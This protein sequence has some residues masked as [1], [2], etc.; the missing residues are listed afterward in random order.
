MA[1]SFIQ[2]F[3]LRLDPNSILNTA[4]FPWI[5]EDALTFAF[6]RGF[7][8]KKIPRYRV[9][10]LIKNPAFIKK[11]TEDYNDQDF[12]SFINEYQE[13]IHQIESELKSEKGLIDKY[14]LDCLEKIDST[15]NKRLESI[16]FESIDSEAFSLLVSHDFRCFKYCIQNYPGLIRSLSKDTKIVLKATISMYTELIRSNRTVNFNSFRL[17]KKYNRR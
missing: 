14:S 6:D 16:D 17:S 8:V 12:V 1:I 9:T 13:S 15:I 2:K 10:E 7:D 5:T 3:I 11:I 4:I